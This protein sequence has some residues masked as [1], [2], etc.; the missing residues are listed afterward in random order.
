MYFGYANRFIELIENDIKRSRGF[1][2]P[3]LY[4]TVIFEPCCKIFHKFIL[5]FNVYFI[6]DFLEFAYKTKMSASTY[7]PFIIQKFKYH[8]YHLS[9]SPQNQLSLELSLLTSKGLPVSSS[10]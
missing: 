9:A 3:A 10:Q 1:N 4:L 2:S 5:C 8:F 6:A 7:Y